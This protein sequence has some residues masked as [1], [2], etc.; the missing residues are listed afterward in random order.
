VLAIVFSIEDQA[1]SGTLVQSRSLAIYAAR[2]WVVGE[3]RTCWVKLEM[4][5]N[6]IPSG[7]LARLECPVS[8]K[9]MEQTL[10]HHQ[11]PWT[12]KSD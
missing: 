5:S 11:F 10:L 4:D 3:S 7:K 2:G 6:G 1:D 9:E 8:R 12:T